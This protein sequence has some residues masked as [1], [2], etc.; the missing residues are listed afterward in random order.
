MGKREVENEI[1]ATENENGN[2]NTATRGTKVAV[3]YPDE[4]SVQITILNGTGPKVFS[5]TELPESMYP[6][7]LQFAVMKKLGS[8]GACAGRE[9]TD[10]EMQMQK[11]WEALKSGEW[12]VR[13]TASPVIK[14]KANDIAA[15][16]ALLS[17]EERA[18][19]IEALKA[20]GI[21][22]PV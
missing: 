6:Q 8:Q 18:A 16:L 20:L 2:E 9:G 7:L 10:A 11:V 5:V 1:E 15:R 12:S 22:L 17:E 4:N 13:S 19:K 14:V 21:D 3:D